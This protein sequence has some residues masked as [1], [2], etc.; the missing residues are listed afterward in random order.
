MNLDGQKV[1]SLYLHQGFHHCNR[2][3]NSQ[4][5]MLTKQK[6][7]LVKFLR[8]SPFRDLCGN[9]KKMELKDDGEMKIARIN[10]IFHL[11]FCIFIG[12]RW[13]FIRFYTILYFS[14]RPGNFETF[15]FEN[16]IFF[17][18]YKNLFRII[19]KSSD[20]IHSTCPMSKCKSFFLKYFSTFRLYL[21]FYANKKN[22]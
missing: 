14:E 6:V 11:A 7:I 13:F 16:S 17:R 12:Q 5:R 3:P 18:S 21:A 22:S 9:L 10:L 4:L 19:W 8:F 2:L 20:M 1:R 15:L